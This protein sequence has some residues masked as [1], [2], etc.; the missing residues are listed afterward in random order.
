MK[1]ETVRK[2]SESFTRATLRVSHFVRMPALVLTNR[3]TRQTRLEADRER[4]ITVSRF[5][6]P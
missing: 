5:N 3:E 2:A 6:C 1:R 4:F